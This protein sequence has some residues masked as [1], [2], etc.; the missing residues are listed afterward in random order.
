MVWSPFG[1]SATTKIAT[2]IWDA[3]R[4]GSAD[5]DTSQGRLK[6]YAATIDK[7]LHDLEGPALAKIK[8]ELDLFYA[9]YVKE[10]ADQNRQ[11]VILIES[12]T[13]ALSIKGPDQEADAWKFSRGE[14]ISENIL[15]R[16]QS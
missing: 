9:C 13:I 14:L 4:I 6:F 2:Y 12:T 7:F 3:Y 5:L 16:R 10:S 11:S 15:Q 1:T 8:G